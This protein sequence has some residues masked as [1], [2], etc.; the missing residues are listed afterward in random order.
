MTV[1]RAMALRLLDYLKEE[2]IQAEKLAKAQAKAAKKEKK[3]V[4]S[5]K[6]TSRNVSL[7][8]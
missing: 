8:T 3:E 7:P 1:E 4:L 2:Q 6:S 5:K